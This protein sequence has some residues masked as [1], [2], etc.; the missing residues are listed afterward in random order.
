MA[1]YP[2][3]PNGTGRTHFYSEFDVPEMPRKLDGITYYIYF[4]IFFDGTKPHGLMN[5]FVS[6]L[7]LGEAL[8]GSTGP[9]LYRAKFGSH[10]SWAFGS[11]YFFDIVNATSDASEAHAAY[12][13]LHPARAGE[14]LWT[15]YELDEDFVWHLT[16][17]VKGDPSRT[18]ALAVPKPY[19]GLL[20]DEGASWREAHFSTVH[21]NS[22]WELYGMRD[23]EHY[24]GSAS[25][26]DMRVT[27]PS[28]GAFPWEP[29]WTEIEQPHCG[30]A[31]PLSKIVET[32]NHSQQAVFWDVFWGADPYPAATTFPPSAAEPTRVDE[33]ELLVAI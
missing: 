12:G 14:V 6:Q 31:G 3:A 16:M 22:C 18:S 10:A 13:A 23:R 30:A 20:P 19:M 32:H 21:V 9:P 29:R 27:Q 7:I 8:D 26:Y 15:R 1:A 11:H 5:Q 4:N 33:P 2:V 28:P 17:G 24:P 25:R